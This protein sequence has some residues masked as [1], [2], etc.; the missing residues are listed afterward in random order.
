MVFYR[1]DR[2]TCTLGCA[3]RKFEESP[4]LWTCG[5][6]GAQYMVSVKTAKIC[7]SPMG[8][9]TAVRAHVQSCY[10]FSLFLFFIF[11]ST[12]DF[13]FLSTIFINN[14]FLK[15]KHANINVKSRRFGI[16]MTPLLIHF[17]LRMVS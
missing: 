13:V 6:Q 8:P 12:G 15:H 17:A 3:L 7:W 4:K 10:T 14:D 2:K 5:I 11:L 9:P 1:L 16:I